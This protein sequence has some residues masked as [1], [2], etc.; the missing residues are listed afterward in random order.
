MEY[1]FNGWIW[2]GRR[3][4]GV[5][6][7]LSTTRLSQHGLPFPWC[8]SLKE[9]FMLKWN[10][11]CQ[12][13]HTSG[14]NKGQGFQDGVSSLMTL[15]VK[16]A[17]VAQNLLMC[18]TMFAG[19]SF[20]HV[21]YALQT[22]KMKTAEVHVYKQHLTDIILPVPDGHHRPRHSSDTSWF[23]IKPDQINEKCPWTHVMMG[24]LW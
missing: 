14:V 19:I 23:A 18:L 10:P 21:C 7:A 24:W 6:S 11:Y 8:E 3:H 2:P 20:S 4:L 1:V 16:H 22:C 13:Q 5:W 9:D 12:P 17:Q 15:A